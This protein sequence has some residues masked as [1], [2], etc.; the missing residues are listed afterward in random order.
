MQTIELVSEEQVFDAVKSKGPLI[1]IEIRHILKSGDSIIIGATLSTLVSRG[2][3]L[4]TNIKR[5]GSPFYYIKGQEERL[6]ELSKFLNEKDRQTFEILRQKHVIKDSDE[7]PLT[8][9]SLRNIPD[10][11]KQ[12]IEDINGQKEIFWKWYLLSDEEA[13]RFISRKK[14]INDAGAEKVKGVQ[15][16]KNNAGENEV[17]DEPAPKE[18]KRKEQKTTEKEGFLEVKEEVQQQLASNIPLIISQFN[19]SFLNKISST[20]SEGKII[21]K[22]VKLVKKGAEYDLSIEIPTPIGNLDYFCKAKSKKKCNEGDLSSAYI[23]GQNLR[24]PVLFL[25]F[26]EITKKAKDKLKTDF[27]GMAIKEI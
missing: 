26:G 8:R 17:K 15:D 23:Q 12:F 3:V 20:L 27:K 6:A 16:E 4:I 13:A 2:K 18:K 14:E 21:I 10:F 7:D 5:G 11:A 19:D 24:L 9:V 22:E 25:V 1:P